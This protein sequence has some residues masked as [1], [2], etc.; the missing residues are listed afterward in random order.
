MTSKMPCAC[1]TCERHDRIQAVADAGDVA[2]MRAI[3]TELEEESACLGLDVSVNKCIMAGTWR[4]AREQLTA[5][6]AKC[7]PPNVR[8]LTRPEG[9]P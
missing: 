9:T 2:A 5:A 6:L 3:I 4:G 8:P 1:R 7:P